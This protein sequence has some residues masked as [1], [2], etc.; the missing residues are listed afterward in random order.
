VNQAKNIPSPPGCGLVNHAIPQALI[1]P[2]N[3]RVLVERI[4]EP[5]KRGLIHTPECAVQQSVWTR[6]V[7]VGPGKRDKEGDFYPTMVKPGQI[8]II[9]PYTD[10]EEGQQVLIQEADIRCIVD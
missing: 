1:W 9:G 6:I 2:R 8:A 5:S 10:F 4:P 3:D 7:A